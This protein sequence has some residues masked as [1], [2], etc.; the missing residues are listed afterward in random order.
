MQTVES[1]LEPARVLLVDDDP[2]MRE[3]GQAK[4]KDAGCTVVL[5]ENGEVAL[6]RLAEESIDLIVADLDMPILNGFELTKT[7]R[8]NPRLSEIPV[9]VITSSDHT[10]AVEKA[11]AA[12]ATSFL[13]KP[14]NWTMFGNAVKFVLRASQDQKALRNARDQA[15]AGARF[16]DNLMSMMSHELRTP[17]N[18]II[19]FG[20]IIGD[21][22]EQDNDH[23]HKEYADYIIDGGKRLLNTISDI[24]L[25]SDAASGELS[26]AEN[27][28]SVK[29]II[30]VAVHRHELTIA[31]KKA[32]VKTSMEDPDATIIADSALLSR[33]ISKLIDN[34]LKF[35]SEGVEISI[36]TG[37]L[38]NGGLGILVKDNGPGFDDTLLSEVLQPFTQS[39]MTLRRSKEGLGIGLPLVM[40]IA[41]AHEATFKMKSKPGE[42]T[43]GLI[44]VPVNRVAPVNSAKAVANSVSS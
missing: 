16:K 24:L 26:V 32:N 14:I 36:S 34:A 8:D 10:Q 4:L 2:I 19:G 31:T 25:A 40:S 43:Q 18:A 20:Q 1:T 28:C 5:A 13:A 27:E 41:K 23:M 37:L 7:V 39:D 29:E 44:V 3:L 30:D 42:G 35:S 33:A 9:I 38:K 17:L 6:K 22:F 11:F 15:E 12:G 21:V